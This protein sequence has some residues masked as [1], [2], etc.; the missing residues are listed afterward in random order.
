MFLTLRHK[1]R[2]LSNKRTWVFTIFST[3]YSSQNVMLPQPKP[4]FSK[5]F[6]VQQ[7][8]NHLAII[9][10]VTKSMLKERRDATGRKT[11]AIGYG[12]LSQTPETEDQKHAT[13]LGCVEINF[14][15]KKKPIYISYCIARILLLNCR[16]FRAVNTRLM[17][18]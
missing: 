5:F 2:N 14:L 8:R 15:F 17:T 11:C 7:I 4:R 18:K 10:P 1:L 16:F 9:R 12:S 6:P 13:L 3:F